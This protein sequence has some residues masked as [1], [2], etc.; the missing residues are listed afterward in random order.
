MKDGQEG[1]MEKILPRVKQKNIMKIIILIVGEN[2]SSPQRILK[3][4]SL[5]ILR[6][7][8]LTCQRKLLTRLK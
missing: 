3:W 8:K 6:T 1:V 7:W 4:K 5:N 2:V